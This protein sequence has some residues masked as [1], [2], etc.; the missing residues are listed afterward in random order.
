MT[1]FDWFSQKKEMNAVGRPIHKLC[2]ESTILFFARLSESKN[3]KIIQMQYQCFLYYFYYCGQRNSVHHLT[4]EFL[5][6]NSVTYLGTIHLMIIRTFIKQKYK[7]KSLYL[8]M[9][10]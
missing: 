4:I 1:E 9:R 6:Q 7:F 8:K 5:S 3:S 10:R 2:T